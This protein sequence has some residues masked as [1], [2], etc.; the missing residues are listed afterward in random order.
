MFILFDRI[1]NNNDHGDANIYYWVA[2]YPKEWSKN[3][4]HNQ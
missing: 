3:V 4:L 1:N 2:V